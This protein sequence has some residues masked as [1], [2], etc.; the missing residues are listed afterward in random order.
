LTN[1]PGVLA[2]VSDPD[3]R[4]ASLTPD[5]AEAAIADGRITGGM[6]PKIRSAVESVRQGVG[7]I[8]I[9]DGR[10]PHILLS[11]LML[12]IDTGT[13]IHWNDK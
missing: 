13:R 6:I 9:L 11:A 4:I 2:D 1:V 10:V 3:S 7:E 12:D 8:R 5:E